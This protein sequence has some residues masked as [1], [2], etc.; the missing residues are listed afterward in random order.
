M[1]DEVRMSFSGIVGP[2]KHVA[3]SFTQGEK[4][5]EGE[6]PSGKIKTNKGFSE[7]EK[8]SLEGYMIKNKDYIYSE[9]KKIN[10][11][12]AFLGK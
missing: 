1:Q 6:L 12:R 11:M 10:P 7:E 5:A 4:Y 9:A 3:V 8:E 2:D